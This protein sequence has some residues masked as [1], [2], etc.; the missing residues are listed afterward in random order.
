VNR[1]I[2]LLTE[3]LDQ[4]WTAQRLAKSVGASQSTVFSRF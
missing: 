3:R 1:A 2:A 4:P